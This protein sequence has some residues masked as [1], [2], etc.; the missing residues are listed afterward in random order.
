VARV[1]IVDDEAESAEIV[2]MFLET[3]GHEAK[4]ATS[5]R[6]AVE[7]GVSYRPDVLITDYILADGDG[8][9]VAQA[10]SDVQPTLRVLVISGLLPDDIRRKSKT[11]RTYEVRMK[12]VDLDDIARYVGAVN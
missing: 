4:M 9:E 3:K 8:T 10:L 12:P 11:R 6:E 7:I 1:L 5:R 2:A